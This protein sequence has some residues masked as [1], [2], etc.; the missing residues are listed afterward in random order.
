MFYG[1]VQEVISAGITQEEMTQALKETK[2]DM[3]RSKRIY[4]EYEHNHPE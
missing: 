4:E 1:Y 3:T 2:V